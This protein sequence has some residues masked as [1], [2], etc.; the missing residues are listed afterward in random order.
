MLELKLKLKMK[1]KLNDDNGSPNGVLRLKVKF[2]D[3]ND[4][5]N[6]VLASRWRRE[7]VMPLLLSTPT[8]PSRCALN[9]YLRIGRV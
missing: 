8:I 4:L 6:D 5:P 9:F 3:D 1:M 7:V 2:G